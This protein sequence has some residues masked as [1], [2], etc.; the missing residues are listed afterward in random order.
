[1]PYTIRNHGDSLYTIDWF[2][3]KPGTYDVQVKY[4]N[5]I[6]VWGS[7]I[8]IEAFDSTKVKVMDYYNDP[9]VGERHMFKGIMF[10]NVCFSNENTKRTH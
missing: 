10:F 6:P 9:K 2:P 4:G 3:V 5:V 1:M 8:K 7:P